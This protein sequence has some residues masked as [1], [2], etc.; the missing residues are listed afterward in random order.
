MLNDSLVLELF[1]CSTR[2]ATTDWE[3]RIA[4]QY[5]PY[6]QSK[7]YKV[8]KSESETS[9]GTCSV[10]YGKVQKNLVICPKRM[11]ERGRVFTDCIHL[12]TLH[13]PGNDLHVVSEIAIPGG[14]VDYFLVSTLKNKVRD[15]VA[16]EFQTMDT[17]GTV[18]P[19]RQR[20]LKSVGLQVRDTDADSGKPFGINWKMTAKT[21]LVQLHHKVAT[22]E[23]IGKHMTLVIQDHLLAY[24]R[25][26]FRFGHM[27][28]ARIGDPFHLHAYAMTETDGGGFG[29]SLVDRVSTDTIG[30]SELLGLQAETRI[31]LASIVASIER[32]LSDKTLLD[33]HCGTA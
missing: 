16:V 30:V 2:D 11:L 21:I 28:A 18:W 19:E 31:E 15:F 22:L 24:L 26:E 6:T 23:H 5:C 32:R 20:F 10:R 14:S 8:R 9:I 3:S 25:S 33:L 4:N 13:E 27:N 29:M 7:C 12:L 17:T 1:G